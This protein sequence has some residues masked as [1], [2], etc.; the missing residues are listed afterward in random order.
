MKRNVTL[1]AKGNYASPTGTPT[2]Y[3]HETGLWGPLGQADEIR[4]HMVV[5]R[6]TVSAR[7]TLTIHESALPDQPPDILGRVVATIVLN[8]PG[9]VFQT[10]SGPMLG[11]VMARLEIDDSAGPPVAAQDMDLEVHATLI[12]R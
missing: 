6:M 3:F 12:M 10:V 8:A 9:P 11:R 5:H 4:L 7:A 1:F 2:G